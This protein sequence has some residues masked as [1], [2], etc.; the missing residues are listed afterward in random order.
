MFWTFSV[1]EATIVGTYWHFRD[2]GSHKPQEQKRKENEHLYLD[3]YFAKLSTVLH[4]LLKYS[5]KYILMSNSTRLLG[6]RILL[7][8]NVLPQS[9]F[10]PWRKVFFR[11]KCIPCTFYQLGRVL[12][13]ICDRKP[14]LR[15]LSILHNP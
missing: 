4:K 12:L 5:T 8:T 11:A 15:F 9:V 13:S 7:C 1:V 10:F 3:K 6:N 14:S 2:V